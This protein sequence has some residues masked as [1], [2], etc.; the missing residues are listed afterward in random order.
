M[1]YEQAK[2]AQVILIV[3]DEAHI[4]EALAFLIEDVG[5]IA[6]IAHNGR[7]ALASII[8]SKPDLI[9]TDLMMPQMGGEEL[10]HTVRERGY[11][12]LPIILMSAAGSAHVAHLGANATLNKPFE[13]REVENL[14]HRFLPHS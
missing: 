7:E 11:T 9:I 8:E 10:L 1:T 4:A 12:T 6:R 2:R 14:L 5:Y 13:L 3:E